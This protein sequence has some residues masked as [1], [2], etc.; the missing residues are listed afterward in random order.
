M[1]RKNF[2]PNSIIR[3]FAF[4]LILLLLSL[5]VSRLILITFP[6]YLL[7]MDYLFVNHKREEE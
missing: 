2:D 3:I 5:F 4:A 7:L 6:L 1:P